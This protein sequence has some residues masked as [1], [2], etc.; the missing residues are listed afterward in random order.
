MEVRHV[1]QGGYVGEV[2]G[3]ARGGV[4]VVRGVR[5]GSDVYTV[6]VLGILATC[7]NVEDWS[8]HAENLQR[9]VYCYSP[10]QL[11]HNF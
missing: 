2:G 10:T 6:T 11:M 3:V 4:A 8:H 7:S 9:D 1:E 5:H